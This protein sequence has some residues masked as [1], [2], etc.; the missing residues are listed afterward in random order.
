M[1][2][3]VRVKNWLTVL[4][5]ATGA[6]AVALAAAPAIENESS[7]ATFGHPSNDPYLA[8]TLVR[9]GAYLKN[10]FGIGHDPAGRRPEVC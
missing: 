7:S 9:K 2:G 6:V 5:A 4:F 3:I 10:Y 1:T 8:R